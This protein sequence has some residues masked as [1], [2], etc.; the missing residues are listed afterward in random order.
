MNADYAVI[1]AGG[2]SARMGTEKAALKIA[3][4]TL[5]QRAIDA[6]AECRTVV[7]VA[8]AEVAALAASATAEVLTTCEDPPL[9]GPVAGVDAGLAALP[10]VP[11]EATVLVLSVDLARPREVVAALLARAG[12]GDWADG[13][14]LVD[15][16]GWRQ[17]MAALYR[18]EA[19]AAALGRL[20]TVRDVSV[21]RLVRGLDLTSLVGPEGITDDVDTPEQAAA[22][23]IAL[24]G[25]R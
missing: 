22:L 24:E 11:A 15:A 2:R 21:Q 3:D 9:G 20:D 14:A 18:R 8:P 6:C 7:V 13:I 10:S 16:E 25:T 17:G 1:L 5:L 19:L 12:E 23:G 4:T